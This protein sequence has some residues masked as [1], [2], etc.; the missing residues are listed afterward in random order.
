MTDTIEPFPITKNIQVARGGDWHMTINLFEDDKVTPKNTTGYTMTVTF[1]S[2]H[3]G[4]IYD[5]LTIAN[6]K[7]VHTPASGQFNLNLTAAQIDPYDFATAVH[8]ITFTDGSGNI[9]PL[10]IGTVK[11]V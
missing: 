10:A 11:V 7:I 2:A 1:M 3:N 4:E 8:R 6:G 5:Q 9:T